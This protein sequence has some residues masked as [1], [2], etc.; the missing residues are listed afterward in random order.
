M[1]FLRRKRNLQFLEEVYQ[2]GSTFPR[3]RYTNAHASR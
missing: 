2:M 1:S 3:D